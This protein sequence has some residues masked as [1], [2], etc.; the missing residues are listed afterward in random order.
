M[1]SSRSRPAG[2]RDGHEVLTSQPSRT[3]TRK[4]W[5]TAVKFCP[6][7][8]RA[9]ESS[10]RS[11]EYKKAIPMF[12]ELVRARCGE[13][14]RDW[15]GAGSSRTGPRTNRWGREVEGRFRRH[16]PR[17]SGSGRCPYCTEGVGGKEFADFHALRHTFVSAL[18]AGETGAKELQTLAHHSDPRLT[19]G[20]YSHARSAELVKAVGRLK[21]PGAPESPRAALPR[22]QLEEITWGYS[23]CS[24]PSSPL[25]RRGRGCAGCTPGCTCREDCWGLWDAWT[26]KPRG[27][28]AGEK[29]RKPSNCW[30]F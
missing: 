1:V 20:V 12:T 15:V 23:W 11:P 27:A 3:W 30:V 18:A 2:R 14:A 10:I 9:A 16:A 26:L 25:E 8:V 5:P 28:R 17:G 21:V 29:R 24:E 4:S 6:R 7:A 19:L 22:E 13:R